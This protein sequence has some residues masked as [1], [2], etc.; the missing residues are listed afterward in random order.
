V[1]FL[2][3]ITLASC[4]AKCV[5]SKERCSF[6]KIFLYSVKPGDTLADIAVR[7]KVGYEQLFI[8]NYKKVKNP[9]ILPKSLKLLIP[10]EVLVP[11]TF[12]KLA[13][14]YPQVIIVNLPE[15]RLYLFE[16]GHLKFFAPIG[17]GIKGKLPPLGEYTIWKKE[18]NPYWYP[19]PSIKK[20]NPHLPKFIPP[21]PRNPLG[22]YA[23]LLSKGA[24]AIHGTNKPYSIGRRSTHGC[25]RLYS[26]H[27]KYLYEHIKIPCKVFVIYQP[28]KLCFG[29]GKIFL[30]VFPD[31]EHK[32]SYPLLKVVESV[33]NRLKKCY[34][35]L[36]LIKLDEVIKHPD[37]LVYEVGTYR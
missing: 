21:G 2:F 12:W 37:G 20:A 25:I 7:L 27:I 30:Q 4:Q 13:K 6:G 34:Y 5:I 32:V 17:I 22:K 10:K 33:K 24:Y 31:I 9:W 16:K 28:I 35:R 18:K 1:F 26:S 8:A 3:Y 29:N 14:K 36:N 11:E 15:M 23:L 19:P